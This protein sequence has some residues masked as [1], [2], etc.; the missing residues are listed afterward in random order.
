MYKYEYF[1]LFWVLMDISG[2]CDFICNLNMF[3]Y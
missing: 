1:V 3:V 2:E